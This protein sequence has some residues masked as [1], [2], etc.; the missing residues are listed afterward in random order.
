M[1][2]GE[3]PVQRER[4]GTLYG[5]TTPPV[6]SPASRQ[7]DRHTRL[8][9]YLPAT[10]LAGSNNPV[11]D[12]LLCVD[13]Q[14]CLTHSESNWCTGALFQFPVI[15]GATIFTAHKWSSGQGNIFIPICL[16][17]G[18]QGV[19]DLWC[20]FFS[21]KLALIGCS[22]LSTEITRKCKPVKIPL[23]FL[24]LVHIHNGLVKFTDNKSMVIPVHI[25]RWLHLLV[26]P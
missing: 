25:R 15:L 8:K 13:A 5:G 3:G 14:N 2:R 18:G 21:F 26:N 11:L 7:S 23:L 24:Y 19:L 22:S 16:S 1:S 6:P 12:V 17:T 4:A 9:H 10:S 20:K